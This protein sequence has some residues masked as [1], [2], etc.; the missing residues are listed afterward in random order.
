MHRPKELRS[1]LRAIMRAACDADVSILLPMVTHAG[2]VLSARAHIEAVRT[3][4]TEENIAFN[5]D[6]KVGAMIE[7][8]A[9]A[10]NLSKILE[11]VD[12]VSV[13][14][15]DLLQYLTASDRDNPEVI[16]YQNLGTS[17]LKPLMISMMEQARAMGREGDV[18]VCGELASD[19]E[20]AMFLVQIGITS[21][22][23]SP[24]SAP[25]V[26]KTLKTVP[27]RSDSEGTMRI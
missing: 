8:P 18:R 20:G 12:F 27:A 1:Q 5:P 9:A 22:S 13:G 19:H 26:R 16:A 21:L 4:L 15:N 10:L 7:V 3:E 6:V 24:G 25:A 23:I 17:G 11:N 2:D 14:T